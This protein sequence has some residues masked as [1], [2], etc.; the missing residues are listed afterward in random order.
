M[1]PPIPE[2]FQREMG[3]TRREFMRT[4]P[5]AIAPLAWESAGE[6]LLIPHPA[7][8]IRL[9]LA[10]AQVRRIAS[11]ELPVLRVEFAFHGLDAGQ[12]ESFMHRFDLAFHRGGG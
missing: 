8:S 4:L 3:V 7:G 5:S 10:P 12:R 1:N 2:H 11:L 9:T 6:Q